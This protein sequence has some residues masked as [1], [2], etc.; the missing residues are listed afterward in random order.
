MADNP[1]VLSEYAA[2][3]QR[4]K[5]QFAVPA[6]LIFLAAIV[7]AFTLPS[8]YRS[9]ATIAIERPQIPT[10]IVASSVTG[11]AVERIHA[12]KQ[13]AMVYENLWQM[14][15][16]FN[17]YPEERSP[18]R[19]AEIVGRI[20]DSIIME[21]VSEDVINPRTGR[22]AEVTIAFDVS[23]DSESPAAAKKVA[24]RLAE[25]FLEENRKSRTSQAKDTSNFLAAEAQRLNTQ[26]V[27]LEESIADFKR[28]Y[29][30]LLPQFTGVNRELLE[31][32]EQQRNEVAAS[33]REQESR[34]ALL[35]T[36]IKEM[37]GGY[38]KTLTALHVELAA[39][40]ERF[41]D[42]HPDVLRLKRALVSLEAEKKSGRSTGSIGILDSQSR[43]DYM[44]RQSELET[45][46]SR[47]KGNRLRLVELD[48]D[49]AAYKGRLQRAPDVEIQF[50]AL[51]RDYENAVNKY[52]EINGKQM[53]ARLSEELE[54]KQKGERLSLLQSPRL[55]REPIRPNRLGVAL[56]GF[57]LAMLG[58]ISVAG[59][60]ELRDHTIH[61][62]RELAAVL[63]TQP[64]GVIPVIEGVTGFG[65]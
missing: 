48:K 58:G 36:Q 16:D 19:A 30:N 24:T 18:A 50:L 44:V 28:K 53:Q 12:I 2:I 45:V 23:F 13:Q 63:K 39:A 27:K 64:I 3:L 54:K 10:D 65:K 37:L 47:L 46:T 52:R 21:M 26:V 32:A 9:T 22:A 56:L 17:L 35:Q 61:G 33:I 60:A 38:E 1:Q 40:R 51:N 49:I 4:R 59:I 57:M 34:K 5:F 62:V 6:V 55:P 25:L 14:A 42:I 8:V 15:Q 11:Y 29:P 7:L 31:R 43:N 41:S 20:R